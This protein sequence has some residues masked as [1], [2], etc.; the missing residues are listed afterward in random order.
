MRHGVALSHCCS[1]PHWRD[2]YIFRQFFPY[3]LLCR[4]FSFF[5]MRMRAVWSDDGFWLSLIQFLFLPEVRRY[6]S[7]DRHLSKSHS[8]LVQDIALWASSAADLVKSWVEKLRRT[9]R[10]MHNDPNETTFRC[11]HGLLAKDHGAFNFL[12]RYAHPDALLYVWNFT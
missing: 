10:K 2:I 1:V 5:R 9:S 7:T 12:Y 3:F 4:H 8:S 6:L 11:C